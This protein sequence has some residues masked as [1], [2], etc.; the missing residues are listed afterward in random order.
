MV[1]VALAVMA[2]KA[3]EMR[4]AVAGLVVIRAAAATERQIFLL[5]VLQALAAAAAAAAR[6]DQ[7]VLIGVAALAAV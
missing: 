4:L 2:D 1:P 3:L 5:Q 7:M 6:L